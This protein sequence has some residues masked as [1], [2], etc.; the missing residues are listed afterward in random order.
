MVREQFLPDNFI[1]PDIFIDVVHKR[2]TF[3]SEN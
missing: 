2:M 3:P 1:V